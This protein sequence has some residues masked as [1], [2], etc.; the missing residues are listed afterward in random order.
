MRKKLA[1]LLTAALTAAALA[2]CGGSSGST[3]SE[4][5]AGTETV[6]ASEAPAAPEAA[7][8]TVSS[9]GEQ[10]S[11]GSDHAGKSEV[12][13][14]ITADPNDLSPF[15][16]MS[17]GGNAIKR[18]LYEYL[19]DRETFGGEM[20][21]VLM[22]SYEVLEDGTYRLT[23]YDY[24]HD[25]AGNPLTAQDVAFSF[26]KAKEI[27]NLPKLKDIE[28]ITAVDDVTVDFKFAN[29][30][31]GSV[32]ALLTECPVVTQAAY[33]A[34]PDGMSSTPV[35]STAY[36]LE[37]YTS[38]SSMTV[39]RT[40]DYWQTDESKRSLFAQANVETI[41]FEI[42]P[43]AAQRAIAMETGAID[44]SGSLN[45]TDLDRLAENDNF[46]IVNIFDNATYYLGFN[47]SE[48][49]PCANE[50]LRK[51]IAYAIDTQG[52]ADGAFTGGRGS[53]AKNLG[54]EKYPDYN[55]DWDNED[56]YDQDLEKA[57][58]ALAA[59]GY[60]EG[61]LTLRLVTKM[62][63]ADEAMVQIIQAYLSQIGIN[64]EIGTYEQALYNT[65][66]YDA[67]GTAWDLLLDEAASTDCV[68]NVMKL[69]LDANN[70]EY[71]TLNYVRDDHLQELVEAACGIDT[72]GAETVD[73]LHD[74]V[75]ERCYI[76]P[77]AYSMSSK[78]CVKGITELV[79]D[80]RGFTVPGACTY[81]EGF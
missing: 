32:E 10:A 79:G 38:G 35:G 18:T 80:Q 25:T 54:H 30:S 15:S 61:E 74:Y 45:Q 21:G 77:L 26:N 63:T 37:N 58:E 66:K 9:G 14:G 23:L 34:S 49:N 41:V 24:I 39:K 16:G 81:E 56:Y 40:D 12:H 53:A 42:I 17:A 1:L 64:V 50:D 22:E 19:V 51:A 47:C 73:A 67:A 55:H 2:G 70:Y 20:K 29:L 33:E 4:A 75:K 13:L 59:S 6:A 11:S 69:V 65:Y 72:H 71:G 36:A 78:V 28:S 57:R 46:T 31:L 8:E 76:Y 5:S 43:E 52:V 27:G 68:A 7:A 48:G 3:G 44:T 62:S 60:K